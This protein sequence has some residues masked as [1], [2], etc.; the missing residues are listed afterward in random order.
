MKSASK[1]RTARGQRDFVMAKGVGF[2]YL[3]YHAFLA[4]SQLSEFVPPLL[5]MRDGLLF[6]EWVESDEKPLGETQ[7]RTSYSPLAEPWLERIASYIAA[8]VRRLP[9]PTA[10]M[11]EQARC[12]FT[13][14]LNLLAKAMSKAYGGTVPARLMRSR[15]WRRLAE[16][17]CPAPTL[18]DGKMRPAE[19]VGGSAQRVYLKTD[20]EQHGMGKNELNIVD[21]AYDLAEATLQFAMSPE[22]EERL[23]SRYCEESGDATVGARLFLNK[24]LAGLWTMAAAGRNLGDRRLGQGQQEFHA[25]L[26]RAFDFL[27]I[28]AARHCGAQLHRAVGHGWHRFQDTPLRAEFPEEKDALPGVPSKDI[29]SPLVMLDVDGVIDRRFFGFPTTTWAG[30]QALALLHAHGLPIALNTARSTGEVKE[31][32]AAYG[33]A[34]GVAE[35]GGYVFD[36]A[37]QRGQVLISEAAQEQLSRAR[38]GLLQIPGVFLHDGYEFSIKACIYKEGKAAPLPTPLIRVFL[39]QQGLSSLSL[40]QTT[41]DSTITAEGADKGTGLQ[42][43]LDF[44]GRQGSEVVAI[45]DSEPD[46]AMF[47]VAQRSF[48]PGHI[49]CAPQA[50]LLGCEITP[51]PFQRGF[52][53]AVRRLIHPA[54]GHCP[55]CRASDLRIK[56]GDDLFFD[57]LRAADEHR[58]R[59][60]LRALFHPAVFHLFQV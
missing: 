48:A 21:P 15:V 54:G 22:E 30:M 16:Q 45:G 20:F 14:G 39:A 47:R 41:V 53:H 35:Y 13:Y 60:L 19:W 4:G 28:H 36:A 1:R 17:V 7:V 44:V 52:L 2:G 11:R 10:S 18:I 51:L 26:V 49:R 46:L 3:S 5:G 43:L 40:R 32:C 12:R 38:T 33:C 58:F 25:D 9:L 29:G 34:F 56:P 31:Y 23:L 55:R 27:T 59:R 37:G 6:T 8:R 42:R 57:L 50:R 24:L